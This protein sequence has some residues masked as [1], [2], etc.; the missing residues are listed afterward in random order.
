M[1]TPSPTTI[2]D[3]YYSSTYVRLLFDY[4]SLQGLDAQQ[5]LGEA[6]PA[7][8]DRGLGRYAGRHWRQML[9]RAAAALQDPLL[10]LHL[11][12]QIRTAHLGVLGYVLHACR[13]VGAALLRWQQYDRLI[14]H[15]A[16]MDV[17]VEPHT[18]TI[19]WR[20]APE[21]MGALVDETALT[22]LV[23][24]ARNITVGAPQIEAVRFP[25]PRPADVTPYEAYF[26]CPVLFDQPLPGVRFA[27]D[28][29][30]QPLR[31]PDDALLDLMEQQARTLLAQLP[32]GD[33]L[34]REVRQ[35]ITRQLQSGEPS[36]EPI[37][38]AMHI[39][40]RTLHRRLSDRGLQ[41]RQLC[42]DT[43]RQLA[44]NHLRDPRLSLAE[45]AWLL[46]YSEHSAFTRAFRRWTGVS[47]Q[48]WRSGSG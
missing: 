8:A 22:A 46:G 26:G 31:Q 17:R 3:V 5:V 24:F 18:V 36:L 47:P 23:Q 28:L 29:L 21:S 38:A 41:F 37:A 12:Q 48:Q 27:A 6:R 2:H 4:L 1:A 32:A 33:E 10:G 13:D 35:A 15:V 11:G 7:D 30:Q 19:E 42:D 14:A 43:R 20:N 45:V 40:P 9:E 25:H 16:Q 44:E 34:E 39:T